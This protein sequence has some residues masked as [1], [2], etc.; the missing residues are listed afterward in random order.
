M[1][2]SLV[3]DLGGTYSRFAL[4]DQDHHMSCQD[5]FI[6]NQFNSFTDVI[7]NYINLHQTE[8]QHTHQCCIAV[9]GPVK[10]GQAQLTNINWHL[11]AR[12][13]S[14]EL[15]FE[16][17]EI[18]NDFHS[19]GFSIPLLKNDCVLNLQKGKLDN[20][21]MKA[22][23]GAG[24]GLG[25]ALI[26][27]SNPGIQVFPSEGGHCDFSPI[28]ARQERLLKFLQQKY[29]HVSVEHI[30]SGHG[31]EHLFEFICTDPDSQHAHINFNSD[32]H[33]C[34][35]ITGRKVIQLANEKQ[36]PAAI[37]SI[38]LFC[39]IYAAFIGNV[40]LMTLPYGGIYITGGIARHI[41]PYLEEANFL[42]TFRAK[43]RLS[44]LLDD[45]PIQYIVN[46]NANL[47]GAGYYLNALPQVQALSV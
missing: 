2:Q 10:N 19:L 1:S 44:S 38:R 45:I 23:L 20:N 30:L 34:N 7:K 35:D 25:V 11:D 15:P 6:N 41:L 14:D 17:I 36:D 47:L 13:L 27:Q 22:I 29:Q 33:T 16:R 5:T 37:A 42:N 43:G 21:C 26:K 18:I 46:K 8:I 24:T 28:N 40:A 32:D 39:E 3:I 4:M 31:L 12:A 9:A